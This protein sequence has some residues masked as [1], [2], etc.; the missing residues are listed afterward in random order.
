MALE[1]LENAD[2]YAKPGLLWDLTVEME[3]N[4]TESMP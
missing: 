4:V 3:D 1:D 2:A